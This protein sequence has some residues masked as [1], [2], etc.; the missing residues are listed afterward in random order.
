MEMDFYTKSDIIYSLKRIEELINC[1]IFN[2]GNRSNP[3]V[4]SAIMEL[5]ILVRDLMAK[6]KIYA[7]SVEFSDDIIITDRVKNISDAIRFCRNAVCH[8]N[9]PDVNVNSDAC[10]KARLNFNI[11]YGKGILAR[12]GDIELRSDYDD[13]VCF[14]FGIQRLYLKRHIIRAYLEVKERLSPFLGEI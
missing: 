14:F 3:L 12:V 13:D 2:K 1:G 10:I 8:I 7:E 5:L 9:T 11:I 4:R 6:C